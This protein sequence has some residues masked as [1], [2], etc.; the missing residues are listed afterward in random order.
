MDSKKDLA[1]KDEFN[2]T[3]LK[4]YF[5]PMFCYY[6]KT[7]KEFLK[8]RKIHKGYILCTLK[9]KCT[10]ATDK[11]SVEWWQQIKSKALVHVLWR[12]WITSHV[13][14]TM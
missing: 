10:T 6:K 9:Y 3:C 4:K 13:E 5:F 14:S 7:W 11:R 8:S 2:D 1:L 12:K